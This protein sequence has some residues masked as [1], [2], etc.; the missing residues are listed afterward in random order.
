MYDWK[1]KF[2]EISKHDFD[3]LEKPFKKTIKNKLKWLQN[4]FD[5]I[6]H[7]PLRGKLKGLFKLRVG[8]YR[9]I[10]EIDWNQ[11][12][13]YVLAIGHRKDIYKKTKG[14]L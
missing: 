3:K 8:D 13:I 12:I 1:V 2:T 5:K 9:I 4:N 7:L 6:P 14:S 11:K 10:Y